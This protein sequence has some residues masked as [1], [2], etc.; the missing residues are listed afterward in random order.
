MICSDAPLF[1]VLIIF[2]LY[3]IQ[4]NLYKIRLMELGQWITKKSKE[5]SRNREINTSMNKFKK[6]II[7]WKDLSFYLFDI[8]GPTTFDLFL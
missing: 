3:L 5:K 8:C 4:L 6:G 1:K 2:S 7:L